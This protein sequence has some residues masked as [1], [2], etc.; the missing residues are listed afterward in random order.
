MRHTFSVLWR[1]HE[2]LHVYHHK[3]KMCIFRLFFLKKIFAYVIAYLRVTSVG[4]LMAFM[5]RSHE[6]R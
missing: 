5:A 4:G 2:L 1:I 3:H 6:C